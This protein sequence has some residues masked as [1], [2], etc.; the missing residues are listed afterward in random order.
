MK[1]GSLTHFAPWVRIVNGRGLRKQ[2]F[3]WRCVSE[4]SFRRIDI[5]L[6]QVINT[7]ALLQTLESVGRSTEESICFYFLRYDVHNVQTGFS[8]KK[9]KATF[10]SK[11][12]CHLPHSKYINAL[13]RQMTNMSTF[14]PLELMETSKS[15]H[16][17]L[18]ISLKVPKVSIL[19]CLK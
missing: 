18:M 15:V 19:S 16:N 9:V 1:T 8:I 11:V 5:G 10:Y 7:N 3:K 2:V 12:N 6:I 14:W 13:K 17:L 4:I